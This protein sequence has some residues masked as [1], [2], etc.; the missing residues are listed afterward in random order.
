MEIDV[1]VT[2][3]DDPPPKPAAPPEEP[4]TPAIETETPAEALVPAS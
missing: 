3:G 1:G 2:V 4:A